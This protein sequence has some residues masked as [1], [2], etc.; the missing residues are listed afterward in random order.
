[1]GQLTVDAGGCRLFVRDWGGAGT[2]LLLLHG[3]GADVSTW[4]ALAPLLSDRF[5][6]VAYDARGHGASETPRHADRLS[7]LD[8]VQYVIEACALERP[9]LAGH[10]MGGAT[11]LRHARRGGPCRGVVCIDGAIVRTSEPIGRAEPGEYRAMLRDCGVPD[12]RV[13]FLLGLRLSGEE[14]AAEETI[15][16]YDDISCPLLLLFAERGMTNLGPYTETQRSAIA[17]LGVPTR[18]FDT[19]HGI[20]LERPGEVAD[21]IGAFAAAL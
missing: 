9:V 7:L 11:A 15:A 5:H 21:A 14:L 8:D 18:W 4:D 13:E 19:G 17:S 2:P 1:M 3:G 6:V 10:S 16:I 20:H 12:E